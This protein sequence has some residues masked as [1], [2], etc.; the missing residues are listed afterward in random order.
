MSLEV[1]FNWKLNDLRSWCCT[2]WKM[3]KSASFGGW[4]WW[5][6][7]MEFWGKFRIDE[8]LVAHM[9]QFPGSNELGGPRSGKIGI[10]T[11]GHLGRVQ[12][13]CHRLKP[14]QMDPSGCY[15]AFNADPW[16]CK[17]KW[18][19]KLWETSFSQPQGIQCF[20][21]V[22][23]GFAAGCPVYEG[24]SK[25]HIIKSSRRRFFLN[26]ECLKPASRK[27]RAR[28]AQGPRKA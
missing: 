2:G 19:K 25:T 4:S 1:F 3:A 5:I 23:L 16:W 8:L 6:C 27:S 9:M 13:S 21:M 20:G 18:S 22:G 17:I 15:K 10:A 12:C 26:L 7:W 14:L 11:T 24:R 28:P